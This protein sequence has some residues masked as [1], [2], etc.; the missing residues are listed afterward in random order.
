MVPS[1]VSYFRA[2]HNLSS[3]MVKR[4][5]PHPVFLENQDCAEKCNVQLLPKSGY[6]DFISPI[7]S[8]A[9]LRLCA[10]SAKSLM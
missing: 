6:F 8:S 2:P 3:L 9:L 10:P 4:R 5:T 7:S 1:S